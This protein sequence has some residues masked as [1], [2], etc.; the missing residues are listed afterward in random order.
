MPSGAPLAITIGIDVVEFV[1]RMVCTTS[2][3]SSTGI[4]LP[5]MQPRDTQSGKAF[6]ASSMSQ[7]AVMPVCASPSP[8]PH[9]P[10]TKQV[11]PISGCSPRHDSMS[12]SSA[13]LL[14]P[15]APRPG[16]GGPYVPA[17]EER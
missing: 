1:L 5:G 17:S 3:R 16:H 13:D 7:P 9:S 11:K 12:R 14:T 2:M 4:N 10:T 8:P 15:Y 6:A